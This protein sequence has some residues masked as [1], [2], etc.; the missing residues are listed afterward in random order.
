MVFASYGDACTC[1]PHIPE[2]K[3]QVQF[4]A[5]LVY[6]GRFCFKKENKQIFYQS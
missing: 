4:E 3:A 2:D 6:K 1:N 5:S